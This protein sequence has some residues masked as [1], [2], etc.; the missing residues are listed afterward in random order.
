METLD[1]LQLLGEAAKYDVCA[2]TASRTG[3]IKNAAVGANH[4][5]GVCHSFTPDGR[6]ISLFKVLLT[7]Y[8]EKDCAYCPNR[9]DRDIPRIRFSAEEL[10]GLFM[11]FYRRNYV[12]GLFLSSGVWRSTASTMDEMI[13][14]AAL[15]RNKYRFG[16]YIHL[17]I[18][19]GTGDSEIAAATG[20]ADRISLNMEAPSA[21]HLACLSKAKNFGADI[22]GS[23]AKIGKHTMNRKDISHTTQYIVGAAREKDCDILASANN[24]YK[25]YNLKRAYFSA[26]QP[27]DQTPLDNLSATPLL[28]ENRLYQSDF[29]LRSYG[30]S[31]EEL[32]FDLSGNL[33]QDLDPKIAFA[34]T[35]PEL[36][37][38]EINKVP[39]QS[40]LRIPGIGPKSAAKIVQVRRSYRFSDPRDL[41]NAGVVIKRALP[42]ITLGGQY[43]GSRTLL[44][45]PEQ[46]A[47]QQLSL[48]GDDR[49]YL[50]ATAGINN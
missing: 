6:C 40:L 44:N 26:F 22:L 16:G 38:L 12:E 36:F 31:F 45:K 29:L 11:E 17:K 37:P 42:F 25:S 49:D 34:L 18:L 8:C 50:L 15:L 5:S 21:E 35:H 4:P 32:V 23:M 30:F 20:L 13:K 41:K 39:Y 24:L 10:A 14:V 1:K 47:Y 7:N 27:I 33:Y 9:A 3:K 48:W 19:P 28:R 43:F 2:S 46:T